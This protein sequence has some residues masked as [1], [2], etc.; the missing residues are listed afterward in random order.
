MCEARWRPQ[1]RVIELNNGRWARGLTKTLR[2][3]FCPDFSVSRAL[4]V[5][6]TTTAPPRGG[7]QVGNRLDRAVDQWV[8]SGI[9]PKNDYLSPL[10]TWCATHHWTP[11][12]SQ[13][14]V[15]CRALRLGTRVDLICQNADQ[16]LILLELK[17]GYTNYL[18][19]HHQGMMRGPWH[20]IPNSFRY[21]HYLQ[22]WLTCW[23]FCH[24]APSSFK[25]QALVDAYVV[26]VQPEDVKP[27]RL[28]H[29]L[30]RRHTA[31]QQTLDW[32]SAN[33]EDTLQKRRR[34]IANGAKRARRR[35]S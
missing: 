26:Y 32:L 28:P 5:E 23:L 17:T 14:P 21:Q 12:A 2:A 34:D 13:V 8:R 18:D 29:W 19:S 11:V 22:L 3:T 30:L 10:V 9:P 27:F 1:E 6:T 31:L 24:S 4:P 25:N 35:T 7:R 33:A 15:G 20:M 16:Q